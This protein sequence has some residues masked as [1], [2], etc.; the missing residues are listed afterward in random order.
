MRPF[1]LDQALQK[2]AGSAPPLEGETTADI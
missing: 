1:W 2:D